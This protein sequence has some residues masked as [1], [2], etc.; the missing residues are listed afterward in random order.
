M[1]ERPDPA[2]LEQKLRS[3]IFS[4]NY[5]WNIG[6]IKEGVEIIGDGADSIV[7]PFGTE[8]VVKVYFKGTKFFP[9]LEL[10]KE[11]TNKGSEYCLSHRCLVKFDKKDFQV[12]INPIKNI[13]SFEKSDTLCAISKRISGNNLLGL[14]T[15]TLK[16]FHQLSKQF[17]D[18]L[19]ISGIFIFDK[20]V[21]IARR[22]P[23][24]ALIITDLC[25]NIDELKK[26]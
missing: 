19:G 6:N 25:S 14:S 13:Y 18:D 20:N 15:D 24:P 10:Y 4:T 7:F 8:D 2:T 5:A 1:A 3:Y 11:A 17:E 23:F 9:K 22:L 16:P 12:F 21:K 26:K